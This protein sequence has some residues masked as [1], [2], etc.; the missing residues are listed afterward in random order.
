ML[1]RRY[2]RF[3]FFFFIVPPALFY[4]FRFLIIVYRSHACAAYCVLVGGEG[5]G[6]VDREDGK[7]GWI[8]SPTASMHFSTTVAIG[9][10]IIVTQ[11]VLMCVRI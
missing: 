5:E 3:F 6:G 8:T 4:S 7:G 1:R 11:R 10:S 9:E 2:L